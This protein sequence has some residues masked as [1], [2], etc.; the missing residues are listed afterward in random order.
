MFSANLRLPESM[1][2]AAKRERVEEVLAMLGL[3]HVADSRIGGP[4]QRGI[5]GGEKRRVSIGVELVTSPAVLFLDEPTSGLD[6]Y[7]AHSVVKTICNLAHESGKTILFTIHQP[8]SDVYA[9]FDDTIV[10]QNGELMYCGP[11]CKMEKHF[12][13]LGHPCPP[14]YNVADWVLDLA[15]GAAGAAMEIKEVPHPEAYTGNNEYEMR[16]RRGSRISRMSPISAKLPS[17]P[18]PSELNRSAS[19]M[20]LL[21]EDS[22]PYLGLHPAAD[23]AG[24]SDRNSSVGAFMVSEE[25]GYV[26]AAESPLNDKNTE[27]LTQLTVLMGRSWKHFRRRP[28]LWATHFGIAIV[29]GGWWKTIF[30][31]SIRCI[32]T[33]PIV[34]F[35]GGLYFKSNTS[36]GGIQNRFGSIF[37]I[38]SLLGF[39]GLSA[40]GVSHRCSVF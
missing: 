40:I 6:S 16:V 20:S 37:F 21:Q 33:L 24:D 22:T 12:A 31:L 26:E 15:V 7:N 38:M 27:F 14:G 34:A 19:A 2:V 35:I 13:D 23:K 36:L 39:S 11:A 10:L 32:L 5:S 1:P 4:S 25:D 29:L 8:R 3:T 18:L 17:I 28:I 9:M 30:R